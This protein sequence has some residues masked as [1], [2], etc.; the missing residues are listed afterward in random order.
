MNDRY[1][2]LIVGAGPAGLAAAHAAASHGARV[3]L[4]DQQATAGGQVWRHDVRRALP[5]LAR[6]SMRNALDHATVD[7][8]AQ[9]RVVAGEDGGLLVED[10]KS[11]RLLHY[12]ALVLATGARELLLPFPGWTLPGVTGAGGLQA[13]AKQGWPLAGRRV[14]IA[15]SGPL[16]LAAAATARAH[17]AHVAAIYEQSSREQMQHFATGLWRWPGKA[18]Q[19]A[20]LKAKLLGVPYRCGSVV[21]R[22]TGEHQLQSIEVD[23]PGG[24]ERIDCDVLAVGYGLLANVELAQLLGCT[25]RYQGAHAVVETDRYQQTSVAHVYAAGELCG[26]G[27]RDT[28]RVE[29]AIAGHAACGEG[30]A[31]D[32]LLPA[33]RRARHFSDALDRCFALDARVHALAQP[34]TLICRC[35]D[36]PLAA[37]DSHTD[38]RSAKL[39]TRCGMGACQGRICG[40]ALAEI[41]RFPR[42]G[43][44]PPLFP[45]RLSTLAGVEL[46]HLHEP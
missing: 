14:V 34:D 24:L 33:R 39:A 23:G 20:A 45:T 8:L 10:P 43:A 26:I 44:R 2:V 37:L 27:G 11:A 41:G 5:A 21:R 38:A 28:A 9:T 22:A 15:G 30:A 25:L 3:G 36:V 32:R 46:S 31:A 19:A 35:E 6:Q 7:W 12:R 16:L 29:G 4:I 13:L 18:L 42:S 17:G 1:D 40:S